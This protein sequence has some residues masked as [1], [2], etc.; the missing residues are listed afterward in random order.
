MVAYPSADPVGA[1][2][3]TCEGGDQCAEGL[4][5]D[6]EIHITIYE[7]GTTSWIGQDTPIFSPELITHEFGHA[8]NYGVGENRLNSL[9]EG[10]Y[11]G[12]PSALE[13][14]T[15]PN[16][17]H[18]SVW[19]PF[20]SG[21][22]SEDEDD[23]RSIGRMYFNRWLSPDGATINTDERFAEAYAVWA[24]HYDPTAPEGYNG[25]LDLEASPLPDDIKMRLQEAISDQ[26]AFWEA[27][28]SGQ[29]N[30]EGINEV[31]SEAYNAADQAINDVLNKED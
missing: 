5:P 23:P 4:V 31:G 22:V 27:I 28:F 9:F 1:A 12:N 18:V 20:P 7:N 10:R 21:A 13:V 3:Y 25:Y 2:A 29:I 8:F 24:H 14:G 26:I 15:A 19:E 6:G 16:Q 17:E 30:L 11:V